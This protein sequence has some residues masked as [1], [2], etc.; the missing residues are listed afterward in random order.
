MTKFATCVNGATGS[1]GIADMWKTH[2]AVSV[3]RF[4]SE[5]RSV[6]VILIVSMDDIMKVLPRLKDN[7][8]A[9]P[10]MIDTE[11]YIWFT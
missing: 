4:L 1:V 8:A 9:G 3:I 2:S 5:I 6:Y 7:K 10:D 11:A